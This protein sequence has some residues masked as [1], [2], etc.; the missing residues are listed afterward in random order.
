MNTHRLAAFCAGPCAVLP[1]GGQRNKHLLTVRAPS[2]IVVYSSSIGAGTLEVLEAHGFCSDR[3]N[4]DLVPARGAETMGFF[5][6]QDRTPHVSSGLDMGRSER[7]TTGVRF[8]LNYRGSLSKRD[9]RKLGPSGESNAQPIES[10]PPR[11]AGG[12][13]LD[14]H[15]WAGVKH[16]FTLAALCLER[17]GHCG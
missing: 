3:L 4:A 1:C 8:T 16:S 2:N 7:N 11:V 9:C 6:S 13:R 5:A 14:T 12:C 17:I 10:L 15:P